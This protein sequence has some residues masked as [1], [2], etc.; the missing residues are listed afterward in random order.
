MCRV[1]FNTHNVG[2]V[3]L[4]LPWGIQDSH[5]TLR[6]SF[7]RQLEAEEPINPGKLGIEGGFGAGKTQRVEAQRGNDQMIDVKFRWKGALRI[8]KN[9]QRSI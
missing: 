6:N 4:D 7:Q 3:L 2:L 8:I 9:D 5:S 1:R